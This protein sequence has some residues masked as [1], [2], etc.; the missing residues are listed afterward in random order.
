VKKSPKRAK[1]AP[2]GP[3]KKP[4]RILSD[5]EEADEDISFGKEDIDEQHKVPPAKSKASKHVNK[6]SASTIKAEEKKEVIKK[7]EEKK[8]APKKPIATANVVEEDKPKNTETKP[9]MTAGNDSVHVTPEKK[10][11]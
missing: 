8:S 3:G 10:N 9:S 6:P 7:E 5:D 4:R 11:K 2:N 1:T